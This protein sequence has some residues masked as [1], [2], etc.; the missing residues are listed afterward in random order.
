MLWCNSLSVVIGKKT[1]KTADKIKEHIYATCP[2]CKAKFILE[3]N[4]DFGVKQ[5]LIIRSCPSGGVYD[6]SVRCP[7]CGLEEEL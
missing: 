1:M 2:Q 4:D 6:V 7:K 5:T 3:W